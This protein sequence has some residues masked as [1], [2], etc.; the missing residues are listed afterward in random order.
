[1][2]HP[3]DP[4]AR[5]RRQPHLGFCCRFVPADG[6]RETKGRMNLLAILC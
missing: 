5:D 4:P 3:G 1:M 6:D 2:F